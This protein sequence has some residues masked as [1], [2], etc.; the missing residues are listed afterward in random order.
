M[1]KKLVCLLI[2][3]ALAST[4]QALVW[5]DDFDHAMTD[6]T[7]WGTIDY[8]GWYEQNVL[9]PV[10]GYPATYPGATPLVIGDWDGYQSIP[11]DDFISP[12]TTAQNYIDTFNSGMGEDGEPQAWTPGYEGEIY[13]GVLRITSCGGGWAGEWASGAFLY[14]HVTAES[15]LAEVEVVGRDYWWYNFGG[16][17]ARAP[18]DEFSVGDKYSAVSNTGVNENWVYLSHFPMYGVGNHM[19]NIINGVD[20]EGHQRFSPLHPYSDPYL[21]LRGNYDPNTGD[22]TFYFLTSPDG[23]PGSYV[24][25]PG[26]VGGLVRDDLPAEL[27][28]GI[29]QADY[30]ADWP[31]TVEFDNFMIVP[32]PATI[33]LLGLGGLALL[34]R[35]RA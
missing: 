29:F 5:S 24:H 16:L 13:N 14:K 23:T 9:Q 3:M 20:W 7:P 4:A 28:V 18:N 27:Q 10:L 6:D 26:L 34:R 35:K 30:N 11:N 31:S 12:T 15:F 19:R 25:L 17:M 1:F 8:Q 32:E 22:W 33:A 21:Q 2:V